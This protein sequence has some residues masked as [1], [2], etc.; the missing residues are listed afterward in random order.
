MTKAMEQFQPISKF[1]LRPTPTTY[2]DGTDM[3][4]DTNSFTNSQSSARFCHSGSYLFAMP[5]LVA[6]ATKAKASDNR[7]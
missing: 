2:R 1:R 7:V 4:K 3:P 5:T 6:P